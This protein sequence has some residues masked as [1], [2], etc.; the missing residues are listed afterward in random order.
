MKSHYLPDT[1]IIY[2][3]V[4]GKPLH[5][6]LN[7]YYKCSTYKYEL[8]CGLVLISKRLNSKFLL[9]YAVI[10]ENM[11]F[12]LLL[13]Y[14]NAFEIAGYPVTTSLVSL[15]VNSLSWMAG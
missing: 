2:I 3:L 15:I 8:Q 1:F 9:N 7:V 6:V 12:D 13:Q 10:T 5:N 4:P 11:V 14:F